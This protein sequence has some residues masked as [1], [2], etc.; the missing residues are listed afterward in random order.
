V[1]ILR[2]TTVTDA[3]VLR[4]IPP[5]TEK[6]PTA[7]T[8]HTLMDRGSAMLCD[9]AQKQSLLEV[10]RMHRGRPNGVSWHAFPSL[11]VPI[12]RKSPVLTL[13]FIR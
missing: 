7:V 1:A 6:T 12:A 10:G 2:A 13:S 4:L 3:H 11:T 5:P 8:A 9:L